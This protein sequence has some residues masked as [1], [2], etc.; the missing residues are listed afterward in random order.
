MCAVLL[1]QRA[2]LKALRIRIR[3]AMAGRFL[4]VLLLYAGLERFISALGPGDLCSLAL[5]L[6][7]G[8]LLCIFCLLDRYVL[9]VLLDTGPEGSD[10]D[11]S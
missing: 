6:A 2:D 9:E 1:V 10:E 5:R 3:P 7:G 4:C 11:E 8:G